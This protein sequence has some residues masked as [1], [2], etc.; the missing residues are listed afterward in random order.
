[1]AAH[2][3]EFVKFPDLFRFP[4]HNQK[5]KMTFIKKCN[6]IIVA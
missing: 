4:I 6:I 3:F 5:N 2:K 1:M